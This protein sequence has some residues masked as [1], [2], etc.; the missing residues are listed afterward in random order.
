METANSEWLCIREGRVSVGLGYHTTFLQLPVA[1][2]M[3]F[4]I[5]R[6]FTLPV[7]QLKHSGVPDLTLADPYAYYILPVLA[8]PTYA[9]RAQEEVPA[10]TTRVEY[11]SES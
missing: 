4:W 3:F 6:M 5:K 9:L 7:E 8:G 2:A 10:F 11:F 1:L